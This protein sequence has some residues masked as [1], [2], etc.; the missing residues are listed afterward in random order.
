VYMEH[1]WVDFTCPAFIARMQRG[2][3]DKCTCRHWDLISNRATAGRQVK[4]ICGMGVKSC[5][6]WVVVAA[7]SRF[8]GAGG[9]VCGN[10]QSII[11]LS[12]RSLAP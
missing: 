7:I 8:A 12:F 10:E 1:G 9:P 5:T 11:S 6:G 4:C 2:R 3:V